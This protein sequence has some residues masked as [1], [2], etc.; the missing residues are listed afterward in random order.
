MGSTVNGCGIGPDSTLLASFSQPTN[1]RTPDQ[2]RVAQA[3]HETNPNEVPIPQII[4]QTGETP[5]HLAIVAYFTELSF[6]I[7]SPLASDLHA[8]AT[9]LFRECQR[10]FHIA[11]FLLNVVFC[12]TEVTLNPPCVAFIDRICFDSYVLFKN[13]CAHKLL[14]VKA[15][16]S[17]HNMGCSIVAN[18]QHFKVYGF[19]KLKD[20][21]PDWTPD[22]YLE[23]FCCLFEAPLAT[24]KQ[25]QQNPKL[26]KVWSIQFRD[27]E[28][29]SPITPDNKKI[30][31]TL[32][33]VYKLSPKRV[34]LPAFLVGF[35]EDSKSL[36]V[37][38]VPSVFTEI[39]QHKAQ[40]EQLVGDC[41]I[42][43]STEFSF[44][45]KR[46]IL[47]GDRVR[48]RSNEYYFVPNG[49]TCYLYTDLDEMKNHNPKVMN[50]QYAP[51][52]ARVKPL[53]SGTRV[54]PLR[55]GTKSVPAPDVIPAPASAPTSTPAT[56]LATESA[57]STYQDNPLVSSST[58]APAPASAPLRPTTES[59]KSASQEWQKVPVSTSAPEVPNAPA[60]AH[61]RTP[62]QRTRVFTSK[63]TLVASTISYEHLK[64]YFPECKAVEYFLKF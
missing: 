48:Y 41:V 64:Q 53:I 36:V 13:P 27:K 10:L 31:K 14:S 12:S 2:T 49:T 46:S 52:I 38:S 1:Q 47:K 44:V 60:P 11:F 8:L 37:K 15:F 30:E 63:V 62:A 55:E 51:R 21:L 57:K 50:W 26:F 16:F 20:D 19:E 34:S 3:C 32:D 9:L 17:E 23:N 18:T 61:T 25:A 56:R 54:T 5:E 24:R 6:N 58:T 42:S 45:P 29:D 59:A 43:G 4:V 39:Q 7:R 28:T 35:N 40:F 33:A 22:T